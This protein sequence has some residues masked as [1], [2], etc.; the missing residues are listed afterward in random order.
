MIQVLGIIYQMQAQNLNQVI[1]KT[2]E[3]TNKL[4]SGSYTLHANLKFFD[5]EKPFIN[6]K[7]IL[8]SDYLKNITCFIED[9]S[10]HFFA[11]YDKSTFQRIYFQK[12]SSMRYFVKNDPSQKLFEPTAPYFLYKYFSY[13]R[14][15]T[16][17]DTN[18]NYHVIIDSTDFND[19]DEYIN[20]CVVIK[21]DKKTYIPF[22]YSIYAEEYFND[23]AKNIQNEIF[24]ITDFKFNAKGINKQIEKIE[25]SLTI[26]KIRYP[27]Y[28]KSNEIVAKAGEKITNLILYNLN[29]NQSIQLDSLLV[30]PTLL[31]FTYKSCAP[32]KMAIPMIQKLQD[33]LGVN[34][35]AINPIDTSLSE[36]KKYLIRNQIN[37][38]YLLNLDKSRPINIENGYPTFYVID[39][40]RNILKILKGYNKLNEK[41]RIEELYQTI[42]NGSGH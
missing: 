9:S 17:L 3:V 10:E 19:S 14:K 36:I 37:Y 29:K 12:D 34:I 32:C 16:L 20:P 18:E 5:T 35:I 39:K 30:K 22:Y 31:F 33:S 15:L 25:S 23:S 7:K 13:P 4:N 26:N 8:Y 21:I 11:F 28:E 1:Q 24:E 27:E 6:K 42:I 41:A 2:I 40:N 38:P